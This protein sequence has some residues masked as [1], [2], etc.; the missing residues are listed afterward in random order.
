MVVRGSA[1][2]AAS[3]TSRSGTPQ[4]VMNAYGAY[5]VRRAWLSR[6]PGDATHDPAGRVTVNPPPAGSEEDRP[7]AAL[8]D[9]EIDGPGRAGRQG[10]GHNFASLAPDRERAMAPL[11]AQVL[12]V[13]ADGFGDWQPVEGQQADQRV[14]PRAGQPGGDQHGAYLVAVQASG[15][16]LIVQAGSTYM[17]RWRD[18]QQALLFRVAVE[19]GHGAQPA[20]DRGPGPAQG[21]EMAGEGLDVGATRPQHR[22]PGV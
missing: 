6:P 16:G 17:G 12:D 3:C 21:L 4:R 15:V 7:V 19:A 22:Q 18:R 8:A 9:H 5:G 10:N 14:I 2:L 13:G 1:W 11:Q 20:G